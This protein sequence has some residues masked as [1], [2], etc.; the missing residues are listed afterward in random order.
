M[1]CMES[2]SY[3]SSR[4]EDIFTRVSCQFMENINIYTCV[5][6]VHGEHDELHGKLNHK[7]F[8]ISGEIIDEIQHELHDPGK[9]AC[10]VCNRDA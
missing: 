6:S 5:M 1:L 8:K 2:K 9:H 4:W 7:P 3:H 10:K